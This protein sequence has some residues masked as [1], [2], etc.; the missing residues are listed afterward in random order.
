MIGDR[1]PG[2]M[3]YLK[4]GSYASSDRYSYD[5]TLPGRASGWVKGDPKMKCS[6]GVQLQSKLAYN[7]M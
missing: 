6:R 3:T 7:S 1:G 5:K 4:A 2:S